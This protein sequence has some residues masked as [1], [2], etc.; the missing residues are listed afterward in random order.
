MEAT[1]VEKFKI[2][3]KSWANAKD[4]MGLTGF[5][6]SKSYEIIKEVQEQVLQDGKKNIARGVVSMDRLIE[7]LDLSKTAIYEAAIQEKQIFGLK[8]GLHEITSY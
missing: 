4:V 1:N 5:A 6:K 8:E 2:I 7:Y 3:N